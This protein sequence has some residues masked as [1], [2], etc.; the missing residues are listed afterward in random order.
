VIYADVG[1]VAETVLAEDVGVTALFEDAGEPD[2]AQLA[3]SNTN[4]RG[5]AAP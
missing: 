1:Q 5:I 3:R 2:E 4:K